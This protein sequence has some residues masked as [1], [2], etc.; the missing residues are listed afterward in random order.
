MRLTA[1]LTE[2]S[3][4][5]GTATQEGISRKRLSCNSSSA[6]WTARF[7]HPACRLPVFSAR[8]CKIDL[9][10]RHRTYWRYWRR[11]HRSLKIWFA[12][13]TGWFAPIR[14]PE[15]LGILQCSLLAIC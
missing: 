10:K 3:K 4:H 6:N 11:R 15:T 8:F 13:V 2:P 1:L 14:E 5:Y 7:S 9:G 12:Q